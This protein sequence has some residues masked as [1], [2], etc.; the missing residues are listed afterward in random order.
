MGTKETII[1]GF[2]QLAIKKQS[3]NISVIELCQYTHISRRS[4]YNYFLDRHEVIEEIFISRVEET[5]KECL[6]NK[7]ETTAFLIQVYH[8]YLKDKSFF[9]IA[10]KEDGQNSLFD[11]II[12][13]MQV[14]FETLFKEII[15]D[16]KEL[17]YQSYKY[18]SSS[19]MLLKK[20]MNDGMV[21]SPEFI[22]KIY[23]ASLNDYEQKHEEIVNKQYEW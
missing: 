14:V 2:I 1:N 22:T 9:V 18:A 16:R 4:F 5:I 20:W 13:R 7:M 11:T 10:M 21:E 8:S 19:A 23:L 17:E 12:S 3:V 15:G 6:Q